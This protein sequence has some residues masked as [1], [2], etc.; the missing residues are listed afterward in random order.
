MR[1]NKPI[2]VIPYPYKTHVCEYMIYEGRLLHKTTYSSHIYLKRCQR[3][4]RKYVELVDDGY[5][6]N[7]NKY[8]LSIIISENK[9]ILRGN[10][11]SIFSDRT[12]MEG[13]L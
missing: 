6:D 4:D 2:M 13:R 11:F 10:K 8:A 12:L 7:K 3:C 1:K 5:I 9:W